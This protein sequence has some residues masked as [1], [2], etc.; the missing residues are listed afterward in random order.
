M[1]V[2]DFNARK[3]DGQEITLASYSGKVLLIVK[4]ASK[5]GFTPKYRGL[6]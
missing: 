6:E 2:Y 5:C 3:I 1:T 4:V